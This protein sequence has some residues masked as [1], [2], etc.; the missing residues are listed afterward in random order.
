MQCLQ[1]MRF[2]RKIENITVQIQVIFWK[3]GH[4]DNRGFVALQSISKQ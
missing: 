2:A 3:S 1:I 4:R